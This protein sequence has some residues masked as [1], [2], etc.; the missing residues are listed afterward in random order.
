M[1]FFQNNE[2][3]NVL[4]FLISSLFLYCP[5]MQLTTETGAS[6]CDINQ[7]SVLVPVLPMYEMPVENHAVDSSSQYYSFALE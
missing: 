1:I 7:H 5:N 2:L 3:R 4:Y 6:L